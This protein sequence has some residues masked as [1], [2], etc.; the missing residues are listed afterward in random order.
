MSPDNIKEEE[1]HS[2]KIPRD[3]M[4]WEIFLFEIKYRLKRLD[5]YLYFI[6]FF[7]LAFFSFAY[8]NVP[9]PDRVR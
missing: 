4:F 2:R 3:G 8:G 9:A 1:K 6:G 7:L 5:T